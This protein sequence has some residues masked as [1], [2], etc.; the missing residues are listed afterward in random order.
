MSNETHFQ[1]FGVKEQKCIVGR[2]VAVSVG[3]NQDE[4]AQILNRMR[5]NP[6]NLSRPRYNR[7]AAMVT[8]LRHTNKGMTASAYE[9]RRSEHRFEKQ[10]RLAR[11]FS[12]SVHELPRGFFERCKASVHKGVL[13]SA[14][15]SGVR[16]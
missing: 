5:T 6:F 7:E 9:S 10:R 13:G 12:D 1:P 3:L 8:T 15:V 14:T 4:G 16:R 2:V 11:F